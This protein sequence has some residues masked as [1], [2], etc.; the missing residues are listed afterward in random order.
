MYPEFE[1]L[2]LKLPSGSRKVIQSN[3]KIS[4]VDLKLLKKFDAV[5]L[6]LEPENTG[7]REIKVSTTISLA[8]RLISSGIYVYFFV[9]VHAKN[10]NQIEEL[11]AL[12]NQEKVDI[13]FNLCVP[14]GLNEGLA[15]SRE[16]MEITTRKLHQFYLDKKIL[17][18]TSP[19]VSI[20][21]DVKSS[22]Y[23]G[24]RGGCTAGIAACDIMS[25]GDI[26]PCPFLRIKAGNIFQDDLKEVWLKSELFRNLRRRADYDEPCGSCELLSYCGGCRRRALEKTGKI[27][28]NDPLCFKQ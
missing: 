17:R 22:S 28:G 3:G 7:V 6:S 18:F 27:T 15:I 19:L 21:K 13:A 12:A 16:Q 8:K 24:N 25:N 9:T 2:I 10:L 11:I 26:T 1:K 4:E 5:H 23:I 14:F 20:V